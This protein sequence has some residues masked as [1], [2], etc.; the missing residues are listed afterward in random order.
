[1]MAT[2][3]ESSGTTPAAVEQTFMDQVPAG[4]LGEPEEMARIVVFLGVQARRAHHGHVRR[5]RRRRHPGAGLR[6]TP[7]SF[8]PSAS[9]C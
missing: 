6:H 1:M 9:W 8:K 7:C 4:R 5:R 2:F 3:A